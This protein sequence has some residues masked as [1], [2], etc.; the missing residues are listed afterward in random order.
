MDYMKILPKDLSV[1]AYGGKQV[2][3]RYHDR[4]EVLKGYQKQETFLGRLRQRVLMPLL[5]TS[6]PQY[7][8][9]QL[10]LL[11]DKIGLGEVPI[12]YYDHHLS[13][14]A[15]AYYGLRTNPFEKYLVLTC[16]GAGDGVCATARLMVNGEY[17]EIAT[18]QWENSLGAIYSWV[19]YILGFVP[20][21]HE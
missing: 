6:R 12:V 4:N 11:L 1:I 5:V 13:H 17:F 2:F 21:E 19:T 3:C 10:R 20:L 8:Q 15:A 14:A 18:T 9:S 7:G 16:D